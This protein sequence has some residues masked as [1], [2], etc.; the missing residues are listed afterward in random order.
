MKKENPNQT[1]TITSETDWAYATIDSFIEAFNR[2]SSANDQ[3][4]KALLSKLQLESIKKLP[5]LFEALMIIVKPEHRPIV[6]EFFKALIGVIDKWSRHQTT[7]I[8]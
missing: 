6:Y 2:T 5:S 1:Q 7:R 8:S 4:A 3:E